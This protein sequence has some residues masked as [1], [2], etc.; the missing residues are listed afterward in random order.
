M[1]FA[2]FSQTCA[3]DIGLMESAQSRGG[4]AG[5]PAMWILAALEFWALQISGTTVAAWEYFS[6]QPSRSVRESG[7]RLSAVAS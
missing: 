7:R 6:L 2:D 1:R 4:S 5:S 3:E